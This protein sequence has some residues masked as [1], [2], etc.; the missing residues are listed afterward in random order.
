PGTSGPCCAHRVGQPE[1]GATPRELARGHDE[2]SIVCI[3]SCRAAVAEREDDP[4]RL[5]CIDFIKRFLERCVKRDAAQR[6]FIRRRR[7]RR[8]SKKVARKARTPPALVGTMALRSCRASR[9]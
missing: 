1:L 9:S 3:D 5:I 7:I 2:N 8:L 4:P 6:V